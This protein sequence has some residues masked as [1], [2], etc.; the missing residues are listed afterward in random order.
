MRTRLFIRLKVKWFE[1]KQR[2][3]RQWC[4]RMGHAYRP[5]R[6]RKPGGKIGEYEDKSLCQM[7]GHVGGRIESIP[8]RFMDDETK[9]SIFF[10]GYKLDDAGIMGYEY[11]V[12][13]TES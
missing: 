3:L 10:N 12:H 5:A 2:W 1:F 4:A 9:D 11:I 7:C 8:V 6:M 13:R